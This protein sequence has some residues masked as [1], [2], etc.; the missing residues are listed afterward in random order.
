[1]VNDEDDQDNLYSLSIPLNNYVLPKF[2]NKMYTLDELSLSDELNE[3]E[4]NE[5]QKDY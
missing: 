4:M 1:M 5:N 2:S 3:K